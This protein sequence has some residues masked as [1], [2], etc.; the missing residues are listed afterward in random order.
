MM[1]GG[2][3][4]WLAAVRAAGGTLS[5]DRYRSLARPSE[6]VPVQRY[7]AVDPG[8]YRA[9]LELCVEPGRSCR[10]G[11]IA[12]AEPHEPRAGD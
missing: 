11:M 1:P 10:S 6:N 9:I 4:D 12:A 5:R 2:F 7:A 8:L 3:N